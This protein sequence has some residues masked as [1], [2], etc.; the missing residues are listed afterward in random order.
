VAASRTSTTNDRYDFEPIGVVRSPFSEKFGIPRQPGLVAEAKGV[1][2]LKNHPFLKQ[3]C[4][5]LEGFSHLWLIFVFHQHDARAWKP[6]I[7]PPR[8]G[9]KKRVGVLSSRSPHRPNPIGLSACRIEKLELDHPEGPRIRLIG[10][11]LLD[12]TPVLDIK[13]YLPYA[14]SIPDASSGWASEPIR[15]YEVRFSEEAEEQLESLLAS[16]PTRFQSLRPLIVELLEL[17]PRPA[18]LQRRRPVGDPATEE[19]RYGFKVGVHDVKWRVVQGAF[20]VDRLVPLN[21]EEN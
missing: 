17:D 13:P 1:L 9:G 20:L 16:D 11:D 18:F 3:A 10:V 8:L 19:E 2:E 21:E 4:A 6:S 14:D 12:G 15:R 7:R 5:G